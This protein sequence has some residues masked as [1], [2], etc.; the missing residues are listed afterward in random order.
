[1]GKAH[2]IARRNDRWRSINHNGWYT[3]F[4]YCGET[5]CG[6]VYA[7]PARN[8][9]RRLVPG[10]TDSCNPGACCLSFD[11]LY[12]DEMEAALA[13]D[14]IAERMAEEARESDE[15]YQAGSRYN[16][17]GDDARECRANIRTV[18]TELKQWTK[19]RASQ[20]PAIH[21]TLCDAIRSKLADLEKTREERAELRSNFGKH[22][23]FK[24]AAC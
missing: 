15:A 20:Y 2:D 8:G 11:M 24:E 14:G 12:S 22:E 3:R 10:Y 16:D 4:D 19:A 9:E 6:I 18:I 21:G 1:M 13:A 17:L 23:C 5:T 7:L